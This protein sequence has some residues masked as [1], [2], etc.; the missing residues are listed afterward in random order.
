MQNSD[1]MAPEGPDIFNP[2]HFFGKTNFAEAHF[3]RGLRGV[4]S[5][6]AA[7][8]A[9]SGSCQ[10]R[11]PRADLGVLGERLDERV[12]GLGEQRGRAV[13][14]QGHGSSDQGIIAEGPRALL[15]QHKTPVRPLHSSTKVS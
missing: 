12:G 13:C 9:S 10:A 8:S 11:E 14:H 5:A 7:G 6:R 3:E 4:V 15:L 2:P 1:P